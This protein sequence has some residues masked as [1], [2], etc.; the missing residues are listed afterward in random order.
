MTSSAVMRD[1][2]KRRA[3]AMITL[4]R[5]WIRDRQIREISFVP[6]WIDEITNRD[7]KKPAEFP[8]VV[9]HAQRISS[10]F[11]TQFNG[12]EDEVMVRVKPMRRLKGFSAL[13]FGFGR[14]QGRPYKF[15]EN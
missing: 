11:A 6:G 7:F 14:P 1:Y 4:A 2:L 10:S 13:R 5:C 9:R 3:F 15:H 12:K 8:E